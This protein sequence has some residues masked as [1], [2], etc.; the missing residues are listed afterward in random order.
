MYPLRERVFPILPLSRAILMLPRT[1]M[2]FLGTSIL[3]FRKNTKIS[4]IMIL[5]P[6]ISTKPLVLFIIRKKTHHQ[7]LRRLTN[8]RNQ[9]I[10]KIKRHAF[11]HYNP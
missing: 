9:P 5:S 3:A 7:V 1:R 11:S 4:L 6:T 10:Q 8:I 2:L